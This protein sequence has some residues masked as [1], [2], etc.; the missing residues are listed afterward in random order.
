MSTKSPGIALED[1]LNALDQLAG[2][3]L[4]AVAKLNQEYIEATRGEGA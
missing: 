4:S 2:E 1:Y 3:Y